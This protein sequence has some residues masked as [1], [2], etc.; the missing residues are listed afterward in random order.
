MT[1]GR[2]LVWVAVWIGILVAGIWPA[3]RATRAEL[4]RINTVLHL[5]PCNNGSEW[6]CQQV[7]G[8]AD[9][10]GETKK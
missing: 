7:G 1:S 3:F 9:A 8:T 5:P 10:A 6:H 4:D 2:V